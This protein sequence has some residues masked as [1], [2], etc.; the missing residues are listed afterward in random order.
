MVARW[1]PEIPS[2]TNSE[3]PPPPAPRPPQGAVAAIQ[4]RC[5]RG[6]D[7]LKRQVEVQAGADHQDRLEQA[8]ECRY[9]GIGIAQAVE[10]LAERTCRTVTRSFD[11]G[12]S[13]SPHRTSALLAATFPPRRPV[14]LDLVELVIAQVVGGQQDGHAS[15]GPLRRHRLGGDR[16]Q[17][18]AEILDCQPELVVGDVVDDAFEIVA[19]SDC[20]R[21]PTSRFQFDF[22]EPED[23]CHVLTG[24]QKA[25]EINGFTLGQSVVL[26]CES[27]QLE[28]CRPALG[29]VVVPV[30]VGRFGRP[31]DADDRLAVLFAK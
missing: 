5:R 1:D 28:E 18:R 22:G 31:I 11:H 26:H 10:Q 16:Q 25:V 6:D 24:E 12:R 9:V 27:E 14:M 8:V 21:V 29:D 13:I 17:A 15:V 20:H 4:N 30:V 3:S 7:P 19:G 23:A 2:Y